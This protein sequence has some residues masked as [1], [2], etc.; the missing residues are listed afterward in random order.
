MLSPLRAAA[1]DYTVAVW[2][3]DVRIV[4]GL[5]GLKI[6]P[7]SFLLPLRPLV[8]TCALTAL[9]GVTAVLQVLSSCLP[10]KAL[11]FRPVR[12]LL[13]QGE[14]SEAVLNTF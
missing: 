3:G 6:D 11:S 14:S 9:F 2:N 8:W 4:S 7:W 10:V 13:Q 12:V 5:G 1:G